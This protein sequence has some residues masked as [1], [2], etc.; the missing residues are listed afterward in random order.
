MK[1]GPLFETMISFPFCCHGRKEEEE[2]GRRRKEGD[3]GGGG[4]AAIHKFLYMYTLQRQ[5]GCYD[6]TRDVL[7][8]IG[9]F[10]CSLVS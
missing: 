3:G 1:D 7:C 2:G 6:N 10:A 5:Y 4:E 8:R 9:M